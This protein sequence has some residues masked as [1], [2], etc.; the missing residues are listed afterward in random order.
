LKEPQRVI[1]FNWKTD[2]AVIIFQSSDLNLPKGS[3]PLIPTE[4]ALP[5]GVD[6]GWLGFP[7][8]E[9]FRCCFFSGYTA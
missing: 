4:E 5:I 3:I 2:S 7:A 8:I 6:V 9:Q 1:R